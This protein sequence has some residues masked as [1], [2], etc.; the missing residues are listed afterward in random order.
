MVGLRKGMKMS[1][2]E[3]AARPPKEKGR[4]AND[5][6]SGGARSAEMP[7]P[8]S[9]TTTTQGRR[10]TTASGGAKSSKIQTM[11]DKRRR[12]RPRTNGRDAEGNALSDA[13][14][15]QRQEVNWSTAKRWTCCSR[16]ALKGYIREQI[17]RFP[18]EQGR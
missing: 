13:E 18:L 5:L 6:Y 8:T 16:E 2:R 7:P 12:A 17:F 4:V 10:M 14:A 3:L 11:T 9:D 1:G 15:G